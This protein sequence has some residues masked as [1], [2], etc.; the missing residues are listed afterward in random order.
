MR[1]IEVVGAWH[2]DI[3]QYR[4]CDDP[5]FLYFSFVFVAEQGQVQ[6]LVPETKSGIIITPHAWN[7]ELSN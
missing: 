1:Q 2:R 6:D 5:R 3:N 4:L 7:F